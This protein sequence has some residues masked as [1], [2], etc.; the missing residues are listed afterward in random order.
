MALFGDID[1]WTARIRIGLNYVLPGL[2][3]ELTQL[4]DAKTKHLHGV[5]L[6]WQQ[7]PDFSFK[8]VF[9]NEVAEL[10]RSILR[11][12]ARYLA[13]FGKVTSGE[14]P[15]S[16]IAF[17][18]QEVDLARDLLREA[19]KTHSDIQGRFDAVNAFFDSKDFRRLSYVKIWGLFWATLARSV[20]AGMKPENFPTGSIYNDLDV[21]A[22]YSPFCD[23]MFVDLEMENL[24]RQGDLGR[25]LA[26]GAKIFSLRSKEAFLNYVKGLEN[27]ASRE[28]LNLVKEV[29]GP[30]AGTPFLELLTWDKMKPTTSARAAC[31]TQQ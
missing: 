20:R 12:Y 6:Q 21:I 18:P 11:Q 14:I 1:A 23:A 31:V 7:A 5:C 16:E 19:A 4:R 27:E 22:A 10:G 29:Y 28:H 3:Q 9:Q 13:K 26:S 2:A 17:P 8:E 24:S 25:C 30:S 15:V